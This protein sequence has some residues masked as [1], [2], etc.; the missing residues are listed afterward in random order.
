MG[1]KSNGNQTINIAYKQTATGRDMCKWID[2]LLLPGIYE[3]GTLSIDSGD[4]IFIAPFVS[5]I[6]TSTG[7][8]VKVSTASVVSLTLTESTPY[9]VL[10]F[11]WVDS[12]I[13]GADF[14]AKAFGS[15]T[16]TDII[17]GKGIYVASTLTSFDYSETHRGLIT[18]GRD[19]KVDN[20][21]SVRNNLEVLNNADIT[22]LLTVLSDPTGGDHVGNRDYN[23]ARYIFLSQLQEQGTQNLIQNGNFEW[24]SSGTSNPPDDWTWENT[25]GSPTIEKDGDG[26]VLITADGSSTLVRIKQDILPDHTYLKGKTIQVNVKL[27]TSSDTVDIIIDDGVSPQTTNVPSGTVTET[28]FPISFDIDSS[29][30]KL[31]IIVEDTSASIT[32]NVYEVRVNQ[33]QILLPFQKNIQ[34][35]IDH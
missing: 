11:T 19:V 28:N 9:V 17:I 12:T 27:K 14:T 3:G 34:D 5:L 23:D 21:L 31:E 20:D 35:Y 29:A 8:T 2:K 1:D 24:W 6:K 13:N 26:S 33:G 4:D 32:I 7:E 15:I 22:G 25:G 30:T 18:T 10:S 16:S